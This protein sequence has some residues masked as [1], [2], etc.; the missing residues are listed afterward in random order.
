MS[1]NPD[2]VCLICGQSTMVKE[3]KSEPWTFKVLDKVN[4]TIIIRDLERWRC[5]NCTEWF[6]LGEEMARVDKA[7]A[8]ARK[9]WYVH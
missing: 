1:I 2:S 4:L 5:P 3:V 7:I 9:G 8:E 6:I